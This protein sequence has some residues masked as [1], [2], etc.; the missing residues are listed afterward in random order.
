MNMTQTLEHKPR[1]LP[2]TFKRRYATFTHTNKPT[3]ISMPTFWKLVATPLERPFACMFEPYSNQ[4]LIYLVT[5]TQ[6]LFLILLMAWDGQAHIIDL[7]SPKPFISFFIIVACFSWV[8]S[9]WG[10]SN[11]NRK[12]SHLLL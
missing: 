12:L 2:P 8:L 1:G 3:R 4:S 11:R 9:C 7:L 6:Y 10:F 5:R